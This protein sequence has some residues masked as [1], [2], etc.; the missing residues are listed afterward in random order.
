[1]AILELQETV[2]KLK[3]I[4][5]LLSEI[6]YKSKRVGIILNGFNKSDK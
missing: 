4:K 6:E 5:Q 1:M 3:E 2:E